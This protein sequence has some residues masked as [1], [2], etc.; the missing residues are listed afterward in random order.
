MCKS[1]K[2]ER[3][4]QEAEISNSKEVRGKRIRKQSKSIDMG[5]ET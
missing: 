3:T 4:K 2:L 5:K 1:N